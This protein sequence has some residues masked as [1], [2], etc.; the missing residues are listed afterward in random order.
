MNM[1]RRRR[2]NVVIWLVDDVGFGHLSPYGG[3]VE[4]PALQRLADRGVQFT[5]A[6]VT[7]L[8]APPRACLLTGRNHHTNHMGSLPRWTAGVGEQ[9]ARIPR[10][11]G[12]LSEIVVRQGYAT[13][14][15]GKWHLTTVDAHKASAPRSAW[16]LGRGFERFYGF[17]GGQTSSWNPHLVLDNGPVYPPKGTA[18]ATARPNASSR[19]T[20]RRSRSTAGSFASLSGPTGRIPFR[21]RCRSRSTC[22]ANER[23]PDETPSLPVD[24]GTPFALV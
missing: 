8:C 4:M 22:N 15:I 24:R 14:C 18:P 5:N 12:F 13:Y 19:I 3:R 2:P 16:P 21:P 7:P 10:E 23:L 9:D 17:M 11:N 1:T 6:H 20:C